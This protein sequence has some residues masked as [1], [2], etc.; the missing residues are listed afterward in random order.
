MANFDEQ[1]HNMHAQSD[2]ITQNVIT[3]VFTSRESAERA[4]TAIENRGYGSNDIN[5]VMSDK[6]RDRYYSSE[7]KGTGHKTMEGAGTGSAIGG[8]IGAIAGAI[9]AIGTSLV[10]PGLGLII[11]GPIAA[12]LAGAGAGG[13]T[14]GLVGALIGSGIPEYDAK[15]YQEGLN[16]GHIVLIV[17][18]H[19][20]EDAEYIEKV[21]R[22]NDGEV[23]RHF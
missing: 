16:K 12:A 4:F 14:G 20:E 19:S 6:T 17:H 15:R 21:W 3:A 10:I 9:A 23:T 1:S 2:T 11:A 13:F 7:S 22:S 18:P 5:I 8:A